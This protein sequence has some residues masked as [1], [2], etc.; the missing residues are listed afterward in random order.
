[1]S[2][3][4]ECIMK[5]NFYFGWNYKPVINLYPNGEIVNKIH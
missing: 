3:S 4:Y 5:L 2:N 1:M